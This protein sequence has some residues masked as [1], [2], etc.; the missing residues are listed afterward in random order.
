MAY[1][2]Y[3]KQRVTEE[4]ELVDENGKVVKTIIVDLDV[5]TTAKNISEKHLSLVKS[6][7]ALKTASEEKANETLDIIGKTTVDLFEAVFGKDNTDEILKFY[8]NKPIEMCQE[9]LPFVIEVI[10]PQVRKTAQSNKQNLVNSYK[11]KRSIF[12]R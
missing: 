10:I 12:G 7:Q 1:Q 8:E 5:D 3:R 4:L 9:I 11:K 6:Q 2:A